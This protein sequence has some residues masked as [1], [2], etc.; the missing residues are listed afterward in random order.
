MALSFYLRLGISVLGLSALSACAHQPVP[1]TS[2]SAAAMPIEAANLW[3]LGALAESSISHRTHEEFSSGVRKRSYI[4]AIVYFPS[5]LAV[6]S[7]T[8]KQ[9]LAQLVKRLYALKTSSAPTLQIT[10]FT[11]GQAAPAQNRRLALRRARAVRD[12]LVD[13]GVDAERI[14]VQGRDD[15]CYGA[16]TDTEDQRSADAPDRR[17]DIRSISS[18]DSAIVRF[19]AH[20]MRRGRL[21][22][23][24]Y[25][26][27]NVDAAPIQARPLAAVVQADFPTS[28]QT[29]GDAIRLILADSGY[30]LAKPTAAAR[31]AATLLALPLPDSQ[32]ALGPL[33][34]QAAVSTLAGPAYRLVLDPVHRLV[35]FALASAFQ[36]GPSAGCAVVAP[37][38]PDSRPLPPCRPVRGAPA[39]PSPGATVLIRNLTVAYDRRVYWLADGRYCRPAT[40]TAAKT[41]PSPKAS[42]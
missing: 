29:V 13:A 33:R 35:S 6:L 14:Q 7:A 40:P 34:L 20:R 32:R 11:E 1:M 19:D 23:T 4:S 25:S 10:G 37:L 15:C 18:M 39:C 21:R 3:R 31:A 26:T 16:A 9:R 28:V 30:R 22:L 12:Y 2:T 27:L 42:S 8:T 24:R 17:V 5:N 41:P 38:P 36:N